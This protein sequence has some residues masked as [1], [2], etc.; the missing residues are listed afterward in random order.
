LKAG[1][2]VPGIQRVVA[3][4]VGIGVRPEHIRNSKSMSVFD[5]GV[6]KAA[7]VCAGLAAAGAVAAWLALRARPRVVT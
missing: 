6:A 4:I 2:R 5:R 7:A 1:V 3:R